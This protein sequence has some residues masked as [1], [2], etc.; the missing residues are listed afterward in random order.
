MH[1]FIIILKNIMYSSMTVKDVYTDRTL[2]WTHIIS[3]LII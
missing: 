2:C 1:G 3:V